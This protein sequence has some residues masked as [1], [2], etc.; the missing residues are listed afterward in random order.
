MTATIREINGQLVL[1]DPDALGMIKAVGQANCKETLSTQLDRVQH[2]VRRIDERGL[3]TDDVVIGLLNVDDPHGGPLA[4]ILMPDYD[5]QAVRDR[6]EIPFARGLAHRA[7]IQGAVDLVDTNVGA[8]LRAIR[9]NPAVVV[10]D[11]GVVEV[12]EVE[13]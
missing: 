5:W 4:D 7:G 2:F 11:H 8:R 10:M 1:D 3:T 13:T 9:G 12:F 6:G